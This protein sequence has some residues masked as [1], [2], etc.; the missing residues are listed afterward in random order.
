MSKR[1]TPVHSETDSRDSSGVLPSGC[2][3]ITS[4]IADGNTSSRYRHARHVRPAH[5]A[6]SRVE[7]GRDPCVSTVGVNDLGDHRMPGTAAGS[8]SPI[9]STHSAGEKGRSS[10]RGSRTVGLLALLDA[11]ATLID[12]RNSAGYTHA[13]CPVGLEHRVEHSLRRAIAIGHRE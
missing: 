4:S 13:G 7:S 6:A 1:S 5:F 12:L 2:E 8:S 3:T 10:R 9:S 11:R